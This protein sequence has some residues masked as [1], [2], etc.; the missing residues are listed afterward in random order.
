MNLEKK[1]VFL[2]GL[3][4]ILLVSV[5]SVSLLLSTE[6]PQGEEYKAL[7]VQLLSEGKEE[8]ESIRGVSVRDVI[9]EVVN[10]SWVVENWGVAYVDPE[11]TQVEENIYKALFLISQDVSLYDVKLE[12]TGSFHAAK[13]RGK[14][15]VVEEKFDVTNQFKATSTFV[16]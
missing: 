12:W 9:L 16:H 7:A 3:I 15:Y 14:I 8:F 11:E 6:R 10:Q 13:W 5:F 1:L 2:V 4:V